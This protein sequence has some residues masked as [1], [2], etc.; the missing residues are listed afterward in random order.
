MSLLW[1]AYRQELGANP[2][3]YITHATGDWTMR[4]LVLTL[5][6]QNTTLD[7]VFV[8]YTGRALR[9]A[10]HEAAPRES[11]FMVPRG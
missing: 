1:R 4:F 6:V 9:D 3:E 8:H 11:P 10:L 7:D 2:I 5:T